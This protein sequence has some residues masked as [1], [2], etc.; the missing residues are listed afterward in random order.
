[1]SLMRLLVDYVGVDVSKQHLDLAVA[2][3]RVFR[4]P[5]TPAGMDRLMVRLARLARPHLVCEATGS[6]TRL[7]ARELG[8]RGIALSRVNPRRVRSLARAD[9]QLAKTD[10]IDAGLVLRFAQLMQ[11]PPTAVADPAA[12]ELA[13][14]VRRRRQLVDMLA[15][16]KQRREHPEA[17]SVRASIEEHIGFLSGRIGGLDQAIAG[18]I[19]A[20]PDLEQ[21]AGLLRS[22]P[23]IG[24]TTAAVLIAE[25]PELGT[26]GNKQAAALAGVAPF[27]RDS[28]MLRGQAHIGGGR[29]SVRCAL[30]M[31]TIS[32]I[33]A[34]PPLKTFYKRLRAQGKPAKLAIVAAMRKLIITANAVLASNT[35]W[36][37]HQP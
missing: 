30:Y 9:G 16:E 12:L 35:K 21:R 25:M 29:L 5:N 11:P 6:Y 13:D 36:N 14:L 8:R 7:L 34:N 18:C 4:V 37:P 28:G 2:G 19:A 22:I 32:A 20:K 17:A 33:R 15:M 31:A 23:G 24:P 10:A 3:S 26:I 27:V 1:M